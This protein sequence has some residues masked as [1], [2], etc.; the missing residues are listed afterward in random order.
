ML[1]Y[2]VLFLSIGLCFLSL[3]TRK[4]QRIS[5][6]EKYVF[7]TILFCAG[8]IGF[9]SSDHT[10]WEFVSYFMA[11]PA[12][13]FFVDRLL[14]LL[15]FKF[16]NRDFYL[17][18]KYSN[19]IDES[20]PMRGKNPHVSTLDIVFSMTMLV[21]MMGLFLIG[22]MYMS[23]FA[24]KATN[25]D[26]MNWND[27]SD[28]S[29]APHF[30][31]TVFQRNYR[32]SAG[33]KQG[34]WDIYENS[35]L[36]GFETYSNDTLDG[37]SECW[38]NNPGQRIHGSYKDGSK[39]GCWMHFE[40]DSNLVMVVNY[41]EGTHLWTGFPL[42][43]YNYPKPVKGFSIESDSILIECPHANGM[44]WYRGLFLKKKPVGLHKMYY[45]NGNI[46]FEHDYST[47]IIREF[48]VNGREK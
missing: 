32:D 5:Q 47:G 28:I 38:R 15:S 36:K 9:F 19:E 13:T 31:E 29:A 45:P 21:T 16:Q 44:I 48:D 8:V 43:D 7:M 18:L 3:Y 26:S 30:I 23:P 35:V 10:S 46:K 40:N 41:Q 1:E 6:K 25:G 17:Y 2:F 27:H 22:A 14:R 42:A 39:T 4:S 24:R 33:W 34:V 20:F 37:L 11:V 12:I